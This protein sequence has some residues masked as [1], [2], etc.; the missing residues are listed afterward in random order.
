MTLSDIKQYLTQLE[1]IVFELPNGQLVPS[2]FHVT[3]IGKITKHFIDCGGTVRK[4]ER[5]S[6]QL[7]SEDDYKHRL[8]PKKLLEIIE[9][10]EKTIAIKNTIIEVEYQ[11]N[12]IGKYGLDFNGSHFLLTAKLTDYLA[13]NKC[14]I[15]PK[16]EWAFNKIRN[17]ST[18]DSKSGC[19]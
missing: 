14:R 8:H 17:Q 18:C 5:V 13:K 4:E 10:F 3:E 7:W 9:L 2:H 12:T 11:G 15:P 1:T 6:F 16:K 19:C